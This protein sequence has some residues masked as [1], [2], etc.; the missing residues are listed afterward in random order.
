V[1]GYVVDVGEWRAEDYRDFC[2]IAAGSAGFR[3]YR[4]DCCF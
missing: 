1:D 3:A 4:I 2:W